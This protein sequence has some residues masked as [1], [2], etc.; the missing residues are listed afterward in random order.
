MIT[1]IIILIVIVIVITVAIICMFFMLKI[2]AYGC[3]LKW[4][5]PQKSSIQ[6]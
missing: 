2:S 4:S 1:I 3:F 6:K 5:Y